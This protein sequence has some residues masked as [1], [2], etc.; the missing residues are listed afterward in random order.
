[1]PIYDWECENGHPNVTVAP[2]AKCMVPPVSCMH[3]ESTVMTR[4]FTGTAVMN[5]ALPDGTKRFDGVRRSIEQRK[6]AKVKKD[7]DTRKAYDR[8]RQKSLPEAS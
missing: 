8:E 7:E 3:C 2:M 1:M 5:H 4:Q 6:E